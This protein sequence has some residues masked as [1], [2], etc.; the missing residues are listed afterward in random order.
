[1]F[2][3]QGIY[4]HARQRPSPHFNDRPAGEA[5]SLL[6]LHNI[7]LPPGRFGGQDIDALFMGT[8]DC[9]AHP[10]YRELQGLRVSSHFVI[11]RSGDI[12]QYVPVSKRAWHAGQS[13]FQGRANCNDYAIGIELEGTDD[14]PYSADQYHSL[15]TITGAIMHTYPRITLSRIVGHCDIAPGRKTD[16][17]VAFEWG[18]FR[19]QL[20]QQAK[21]RSPLT[22]SY[23]KDRR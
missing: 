18:W 19:E 1:M 21:Q 2:N 4:A 8:L 23:T 14:I 6:V 5:P 16:P 3:Q 22:T 17:G 11:H 15:L 12:V 9:N 10:F 20:Q 7:S 13:S